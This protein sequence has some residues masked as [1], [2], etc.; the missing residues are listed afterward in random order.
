MVLER[1]TVSML[2]RLDTSAA[3]VYGFPLLTAARAVRVDCLDELVGVEE[4]GC[5][6]LVFGR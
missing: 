6:Q 2:R 5:G 4:R 1:V 3:R